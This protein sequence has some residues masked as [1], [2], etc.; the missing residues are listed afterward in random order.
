VK[1]SYPED[2][3]YFLDEAIFFYKEDRKTKDDIKILMIING[4]TIKFKIEYYYGLKFC[5]VSTIFC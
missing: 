2:V 1:H 4:E 3:H 5:Y